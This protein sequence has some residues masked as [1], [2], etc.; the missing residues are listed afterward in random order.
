MQLGVCYYPEQW[1][2]SMW[3]DDARRMHVARLSRGYD[4]RFLWQVK[5]FATGVGALFLRAYE[6]GERVYLAMVSRGYTGR[7]P[8]P[9]GG[10]AT[11]A[12]WVRS[13]TLPIAA[14]AIALVAV[15]A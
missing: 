15:L 13:A 11:Q 4:P 8:R 12:D 9:E 5:A 2:E 1:P 6:R 7:L 14:A 10:A 3:A